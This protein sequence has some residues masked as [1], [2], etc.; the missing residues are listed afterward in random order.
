[1]LHLFT[2]STLQHRVRCHTTSRVQITNGN[3][4]TSSIGFG[5]E[6]KYKSVHSKIA[7]AINRRNLLRMRGVVRILT[8]NCSIV[9]KAFRLV[10]ANGVNTTRPATWLGISRMEHCDHQ[11]VRCSVHTNSLQWYY[12][13]PIWEESVKELTKTLKQRYNWAALSKVVF[14]IST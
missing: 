5:N 3:S 10:D 12:S 14:P 7:Y 13:K 11:L 6:T 8:R 2:V 1:M 9:V 4:T